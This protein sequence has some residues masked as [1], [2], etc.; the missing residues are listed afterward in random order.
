MLVFLALFVMVSSVSFVYGAAGS[1]LGR[2]VCSSAAL[3]WR[4]GFSASVRFECVLAS[5]RLS[6]VVSSVA[7]LRAAAFKC[8]AFVAG[9]G[10]LACRA[11]LLNGSW[12]CSAIA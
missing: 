9:S 2:V 8:R 4:A 12:V 1:P 5:G 6:V 11:F 7:S 10:V 3:R